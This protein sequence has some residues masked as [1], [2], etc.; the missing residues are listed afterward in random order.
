MPV[1]RRLPTTDAHHLIARGV[2]DKHLAAQV[3]HHEHID[4]HEA[5]ALQ[6]I[7]GNT[8]VQRLAIG[9]AFAVQ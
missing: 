1:E 2:A 7:A 9:P 3:A 5:K 4:M 8:R 6:V